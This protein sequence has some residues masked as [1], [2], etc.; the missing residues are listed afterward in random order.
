[1]NI[2][3]SLQEA[4]DSFFGFLP[5]LLGCLVLLLVG[6]LIAKLVAGLVRKGTE[7]AGIDRRLAETDSGRSL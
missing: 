1:M 7:S 5:N 2:D 6:Y 3:D 4:A